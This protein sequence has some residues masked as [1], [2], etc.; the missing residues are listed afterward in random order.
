MARGWE[1]EREEREQL[2]WKWSWKTKQNKTKQSWLKLSVFAA[3]IHTSE[4]N[5]HAQVCKRKKLDKFEK[6]FWEAKKG[7][8]H[9]Q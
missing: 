1:R 5:Q 2:G 9:Y 4:P 3:H 8:K 7:S 6:K